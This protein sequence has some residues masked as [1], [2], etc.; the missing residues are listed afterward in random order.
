M[1]AYEGYFEDGQFHMACGTANINVK[2]RKRAF[3][4]I[5]DEPSKI[6]DTSFR[7]GDIVVFNLDPAPGC[8]QTDCHPALVIS[9]DSYNANTEQIVVCP[10]TNETEPL[11]VRVGLSIGLDERTSTNG[12]IM[13][14]E[15]VMHDIT[16]RKPF[17]VEK[18]P[19]DLL[20]L[21]LETVTA[22]FQMPEAPGTEEN[23]YEDYCDKNG[24]KIL[25]TPLPQRLSDEIRSVIDRWDPLG[26]LA[27]G[28]PDNE[29]FPE[30]R[31]ICDFIHENNE[32]TPE[33][34]GLETSKI[35]NHMFGEEMFSKSIGE[36]RETAAKIIEKIAK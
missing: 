12:Y 32:L 9:R 34:L 19:K 16:A 3:I 21:V 35:F 30:L 17:F 18:I 25:V 1:Q 2:G 29:Y 7:Q 28:C 24:P 14:N 11:A 20:E 15:I 5:L 31:Q 10:I 6:K 4:T 8:E 36:C 33:S 22:A 13:C 23:S 26:M 27:G